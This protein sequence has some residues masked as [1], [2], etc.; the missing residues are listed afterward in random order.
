MKVSAPVSYVK[1]RREEQ[2]GEIKEGKEAAS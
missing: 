1:R 2:R